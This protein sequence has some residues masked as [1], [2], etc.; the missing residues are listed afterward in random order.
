MQLSTRQVRLFTLATLLGT[1]K[2]VPSDEI[3]A[4]LRCSEATLTRTF[5]ELRDTWS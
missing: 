2:P 5:K 1:G 4:T 3:L